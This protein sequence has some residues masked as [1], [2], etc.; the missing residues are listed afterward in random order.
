MSNISESLVLDELAEVVLCPLKPLQVLSR[1]GRT[2]ATSKV[3]IEEGRKIKIFVVGCEV[4]GLA[5]GWEC[6]CVF[7]N[8]G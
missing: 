7:V 4:P 6:E 8:M 1:G 3:L 2:L 5:L